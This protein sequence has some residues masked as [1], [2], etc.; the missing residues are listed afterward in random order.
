MLD[1]VSS[2]GDF[3]LDKIV[4][5]YEKVLAAMGVLWCYDF[6]YICVYERFHICFFNQTQ[7][8]VHF[9]KKSLSP[10]SGC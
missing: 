3:V 5:F 4:A 9:S 10:T 6:V 7:I 8:S 2:D 1:S